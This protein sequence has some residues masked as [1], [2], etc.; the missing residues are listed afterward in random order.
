[1]A[2]TRDKRI[3]GRIGQEEGGEEGERKDLTIEKKISCELFT[4]HERRTRLSSR[5]DVKG[6][7]K[8]LAW[9]EN[10]LQGRKEVAKRLTLRVHKE[11]ALGVVEIVELKLIEGG[12]RVMV[13]CPKQYTNA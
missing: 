6:V 13:N 7:G 12:Y 5:G 8:G 3:A 2:I 11:R 10:D 9:G 1:M 4:S